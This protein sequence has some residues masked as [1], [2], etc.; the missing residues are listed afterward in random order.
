MLEHE[1]K[2][3]STWRGPVQTFIE[4][5]LNFTLLHCGTSFPN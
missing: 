3:T 5:G 1:T 4:I 2:I